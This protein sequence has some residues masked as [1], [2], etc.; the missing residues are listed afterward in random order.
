MLVL[1]DPA[2]RP[3]IGHR[4]D[5]AHAPENTLE[6]LRQALAKGVDALEFDLHL[7]RDGVPVLMHDP[8]LDRTTDGRGAVSARTL[9]ELHALDAGACFTPDGGRTFPWRGRGVR[10]PTLEEALADAPTLPLIIELKTVEVARPALE[11]LRRTGDTGRVLIGSFLDDA[12]RPFQDVGIPVSAASAELTRL[13]LPAVFGRRLSRQALP[14]QAMCIPRF[15][16]RILPVPVRRY[17]AMMRAAGGATHVWTVN[18]PIVARRLWA[19]GVNGI[20][21]D[22]PAAILAARGGAA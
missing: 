17:A 21:S 3:V 2:R 14:F 5:R 20:I 13:Y 8:T 6:S 11:I 9:A 10:I 16:R 12:L 22:D 7:S 1:L 19:K 18:D 15:H 4:G